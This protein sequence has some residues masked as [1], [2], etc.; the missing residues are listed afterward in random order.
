MAATPGARVFGP[1]RDLSGGGGGPC[2]SPAGGSGTGCS[3]ETHKCESGLP[4]LSAK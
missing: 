2:L 4:V 3:E 1:S